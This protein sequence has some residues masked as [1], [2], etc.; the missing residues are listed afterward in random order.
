MTAAAEDVLPI[1]WQED[2]DALPDQ[3]TLD[4]TSRLEGDAEQ[5]QSEEDGY[6]SIHEAETQPFEVAEIMAEGVSEQPGST[7]SDADD[8]VILPPMPPELG[9]FYER[10]EADPE[11]HTIRLALARLSEQKGDTD[12]ALEQYRLLIK[13]GSLLDPVVE[14]LQEMITGD[15]ARPMLRRLHRLLG[16]AYTKQ[17]RLDEALDEYSWT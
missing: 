10:L 5:T 3:D 7:S 12:R 14:D 4:D 6:A 16:D 13:Q 2:D 9:R 17:N 1:G 15:Y 8:E 11:N